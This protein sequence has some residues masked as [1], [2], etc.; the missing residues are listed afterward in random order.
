MRPEPESI[1]QFALVSD[2][3]IDLLNQRPK[4][5]SVK[6]KSPIKRSSKFEKHDAAKDI[7]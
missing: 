1:S 2:D 6:G 3:K 4:L 5:G 7:L